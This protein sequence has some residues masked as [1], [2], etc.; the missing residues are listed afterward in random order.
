MRAKV[1]M[2]R[3]SKRTPSRLSSAAIRRRRRVFSCRLC[4]PHH[5]EIHP[6][7]VNCLESRFDPA[8]P[9]IVFRERSFPVFGREAPL[10]GAR[11]SG[12]SPPFE[13]AF[14]LL[15]AEGRRRDPSRRQREAC[16][17][18]SP[19]AAASRKTTAAAQTVGI[20]PGVTTLVIKGTLPAA[21]ATPRH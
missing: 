9:T 18:S 10:F 15:V 21:Q 8:R 3:C 5:L 20:P 1:R 17:P 4:P 16:A 14:W 7:E 12:E 19:V 11:S 6:V 2:V 13:N